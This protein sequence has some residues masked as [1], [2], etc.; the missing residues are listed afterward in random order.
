MAADPDPILDTVTVHYNPLGFSNDIS[1]QASDSVNLFQP[2]VD[3]TKDCEALS[4][5][6]DAYTCA[7]VV[8]NTSSADS[9]S[10]V[11][12]TIS[13]TVEGNLLDA[14]N[15]FVTSNS[16]TATLAVGAHCNIATSRTTLAADPDPIL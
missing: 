9:P 1:D 7:Y 5:V 11:N 13:D 2:S 8:T 3:V 4:K 6:G 16:C 10:L 12:G 14:A 15:T